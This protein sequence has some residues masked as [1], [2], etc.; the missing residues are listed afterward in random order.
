MSQVEESDALHGRVAQFIKGSLAGTTTEGFE[1]LALALARYQA[2]H[3]DAVARSLAANGLS[4][5]SLATV[6]AIPA[7]PT[8]AFRLRRIA[9]HPESLDERAFLTSGTTAAERGLHAMRTTRTYRLAALAWAE[10]L[11]YPGRTPDLEVRLVGLLENEQ[12]APASSLSF[13]M[14][15]LAERLGRASWHFDGERLDLEGVRRAV[16]EA[17]RAQS[18][19]FLAGTA[20]ALA[21]LVDTIGALPLPPGSFAMQTGGFKG[22]TREVSPAE[23]TRGLARVLAMPEIR[24]VGEYGMTELSSQLYQAA[25]A[26]VLGWCAVPLSRSAYYAPPWL[27][28][29]AVD[30]ATLAPVPRHTEG[31]ARFVDLANVDSSVAILTADRITVLDDGGVELHGRVAGAPPRGCS[32]ALEPFLS[33]HADGKRS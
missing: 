19:V 23:L 30:P 11:L 5:A 28:V 25:L 22:R 4:A 15:R 2:R 3:V 14:A 12:R 13:M 1:Q 32:L 16:E 7:I 9:A 27:R 10:R 17:R 33:R 6:E 31:I 20:F 26:H 24:V 29:T 8:D 21:E 18:P